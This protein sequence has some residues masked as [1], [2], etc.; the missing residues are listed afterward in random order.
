MFRNMVTSLLKHEKIKTTDVKA[1]ALRS[2]V[3]HI[4]TLAKRGDLHARR[5]ALAIVREKKVVHKLFAEA[6]AKYGERQGGYT[7]IT[8]LGYRRGDAA[9][10]S[11][12]ELITEVE[13][14]KKKLFKEDEKVQVA[15]TVIV[16]KEEAED[17]ETSEALSKKESSDTAVDDQGVEVA[18]A[19]GQDAVAQDTE[20]KADTSKDVGDQQAT[21]KNTGEK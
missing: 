17:K 13:A 7:R 10:V 20:P 18:P 2:W 4:I 8:K 11:I 14:P 6:A 3:D 1:K 21:E 15:P 12:I 5:Q 16:Q 19:K 9:P